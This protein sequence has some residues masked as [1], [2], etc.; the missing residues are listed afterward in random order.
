MVVC[1]GRTAALCQIGLAAGST[2]LGPE[3]AH[4]SYAAAA[5]AAGLVLIGLAVAVWPRTR[6]AKPA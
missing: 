4:L 1:D 2:V 3:Q 6:R 5:I